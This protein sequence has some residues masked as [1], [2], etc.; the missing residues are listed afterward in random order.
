[1]NPRQGGQQTQ[2]NRGK[3]KKKGP[4]AD[5]GQRSKGS[6]KKAETQSVD[7]GRKATDDQPESQFTG[8][9]DKVNETESWSELVFKGKKKRLQK[10]K[11]MGNLKGGQ[12]VKSNTAASRDSDKPKSRNMKARTSRMGPKSSTERE[13]SPHRTAKGSGCTD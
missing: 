12:K 11:R 9:G 13:S 4:K 10:M 5:P 6:Q 7:L 8:S 3:F 1:M 2:K